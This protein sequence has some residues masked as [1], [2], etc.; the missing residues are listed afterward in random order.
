MKKKIGVFFIVVGILS[1]ILGLSAFGMDTGNY[2]GNQAYGG[3]AYTGIQNAAA[4]TARNIQTLTE[5]VVFGFGAVLLVG[6]LALAGYGLQNVLDNPAPATSQ[7]AYPSAPQQTPYNPTSA[8][9]QTSYNP[10]PATQPSYHQAA[11]PSPAM[12]GY[13]GQWSCTCGRTNPDYMQQCSCG[14]TKAAA[15]ADAMPSNAGRTTNGWRCR[16]G[17]EYP[18]YVSSCVCG[19]SKNDVM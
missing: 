15:K 19:M 17:R 16:C 5:A 13:V 18:A 4:Q 14:V 9:Q 1:A 2:A 10:T 7:T 11:A 8:P 6:G 12:S 3:D